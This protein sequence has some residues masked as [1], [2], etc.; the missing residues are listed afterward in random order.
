MSAKKNVS[1]ILC[2]EPD[3]IRPVPA[4]TAHAAELLLV[5]KKDGSF[6]V[7][8][9]DALGEPAP[10]NPKDATLCV[11]SSDRST[12]IAEEPVGMAF[13]LK[14]A[15]G[16]ELGAAGKHTTISVTV[17]WEK[18]NRPPSTFELV[19][20]AV[21]EDKVTTVLAE[22]EGTA[23]IDADIRST[24]PD[25]PRQSTIRKRADDAKA[26]RKAEIEAKIKAK[27][28]P[29]KPVAHAPLPPHAPIHDEP[30][31]VQHKAVVHPPKHEEP[32]HKPHKK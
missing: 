31:A 20:Y 16:G 17:T 15:E 30:P 8:T 5:D 13:R 29:P 27:Q 32:E 24:S 10:I 9:I 25:A 7:Q 2:H 4:P 22:P 12:I 21:D 18:V 6:E 26:K 19:A 14:R 3:A 23:F 28:T 11:L 1:V